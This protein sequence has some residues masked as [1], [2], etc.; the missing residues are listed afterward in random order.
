MVPPPALTV[1]S[2]LLKAASVQEA[3]EPFPTMALAARAGL[4]VR[5]LPRMD[6]SARKII[7][8]RFIFFSFG[9]EWFKILLDVSRDHFCNFHN[10]GKSED[11]AAA[12]IQ[13]HT[14]GSL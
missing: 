3:G 5:R 2:A 12:H 6:N 13:H 9:I 4:G 7:S 1:V 8:E 11:Q 14:Q 10:F